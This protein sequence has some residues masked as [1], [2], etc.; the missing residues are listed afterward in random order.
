M[1]QKNRNVCG[2]GALSAWPQNTVLNFILANFDA[3]PGYNWEIPWT[4]IDISRWFVTSNIDNCLH[5]YITTT[6]P[7]FDSFWELLFR[8][9]NPV[10]KRNNT[11]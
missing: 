5:E 4:L 1:Q 9:K 10:I 3:T 2:K 6:K 11:I 8:E 7:K